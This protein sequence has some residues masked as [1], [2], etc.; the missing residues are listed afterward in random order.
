M[1]VVIDTPAGSRN[2]YK[3]DEALEIFRISR[4]LP[5]GMSFPFDFGSIPGT[6]AEDGDALDVLVLGAPPTFPGCVVTVRLIGV[7]HAEQV[8]KGKKI[9]NDR[10]IAMVET[11]VNPARIRS[12]RDM[13][14]QILRDIQRFFES[15]NRAEGRNFAIRGRGGVRAAEAALQ[16]AIAAFTNGAVD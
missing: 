14:P 5:S 13:D 15:Y 8:E 3:Y 9:R 6:C 2:K 4:I 10:L 1:F 16:R 12:L 7:I 11:P